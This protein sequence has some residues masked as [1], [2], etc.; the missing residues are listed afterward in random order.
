MTT[1]NKPSTDDVRVGSA[2]HSKRK[3]RLLLSSAVVRRTTYPTTSIAIAR[4]TM[5]FRVGLRLSESEVK[6]SGASM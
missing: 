5:V 6:I 3:S 2:T 4:A 1:E